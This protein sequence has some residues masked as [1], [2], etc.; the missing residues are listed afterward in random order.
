[1]L[2]KY[3]TKA[4]LITIIFGFLFVV[5]E[6]IS[7][8]GLRVSSRCAVESRTGKVIG[9]AVPD[10]HVPIILFSSTSSEIR[11]MKFEDGEIQFLSKDIPVELN[12][13][14]CFKCLKFNINTAVLADCSVSISRTYPAGSL[15][16][17]IGTSMKPFSVVVHGFT[18]L[19]ENENKTFTG[20]GNLIAS[21]KFKEGAFLIH[22]FRTTA[23][24]HVYTYFEYSNQAHLQEVIQKLIH[25]ETQ[26]N[27]KFLE[28][29]VFWERTK[30]PTYTQEIQCGIEKFKSFGAI[31]HAYRSM[32]LENMAFPPHYDAEKEMFEQITVDDLYR[33]GLTQKI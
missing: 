19:G 14:F 16:V 7:D 33:A 8:L 17:G 30:G 21:S 24:Q 3:D 32:Q 12:K 15:V 6:M 31:I 1:M 28:I 23:G 29:P 2:N 4:V 5:A 26:A 20:D 13:S 9:S 25:A 10:K 11:Q 22:T 27:G 18:E